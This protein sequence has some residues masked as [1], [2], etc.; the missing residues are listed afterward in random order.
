MKYYLIA[1][2][3]SGDLHASNLMKS[4][5]EL[6]ANAEFRFLGGD[7][8][9]HQSNSKPLIHY[10]DMAFMGFMPV[11]LNAKT[12]LNNMK[13]CKDDIAKYQP[14]VVI[15]IDYPGFNL[16]I[17]KYVKEQLEIPVYY[18][19]APKV[20]AWKEY[21]VKS[22]KKYVDEMLLIL[23]FEVEF[24]KKHD[25]KTH[26][27][28]NPTLDAIEARDYKDEKFEDFIA[29]NNLESKPIISIMAGSRK[30]EISKNLPMMLES[31]K[32]FEGYQ[33]LILGAP[34]IDARYY[35]EYTK[36]LP[37]TIVFNQTYRALAQSQAALVTSGTA[38]LETAILNIPQIVCYHTPV[39]KL[40]YWGFKNILHTPY[41]SLVN[42]IAGREVVK[43]LFAK[44]FTIDNI[45]TELHQILNVKNYRNNMLSNYDELRKILGKAGASHNAAQFIVD[46]LSESQ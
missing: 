42:L 2:E 4:I 14:D 34:G 35:D 20:W 30:Q 32:G 45:R 19:I 18:Y 9:A 44:F 15:L 25:Y 46:K 7:L 40:A 13:V 38:T 39:P 17:A 33:I 41:I 26:Y 31:L 28:G 1:G 12:I 21:R 3:A 29:A 8:M 27:I 5:K 43:E 36:G 6:D 37:V 22:F 23:P 11:L 24:Y 16:K 10:R